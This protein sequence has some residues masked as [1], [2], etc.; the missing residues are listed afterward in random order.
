MKGFVGLL[1]VGLVVLVGLVLFYGH[2]ERDPKDNWYEN[3]MRQKAAV[4]ALREYYVG[5]PIR[6]DWGTDDIRPQGDFNVV[7]SIAIQP[8]DL[9]YY[10]ADKSGISLTT[11]RL[12]LCPPA[13]ARAVW[14]ALGGGVVVFHL[15]D[16]YRTKGSK[17]V[18]IDSMDV[19]C[20]EPRAA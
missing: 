8:K 7:V 12:Q 13:D 5:H 10:L 9:N 11:L 6:D 14:G 20:S 16:Y 18:N 1:L 3:A 4:A 19:T 15:M 2:R 17:D